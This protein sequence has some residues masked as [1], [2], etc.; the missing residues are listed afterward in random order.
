MTGTLRVTLLATLALLT[1]PV[2]GGAQAPSVDSLL[3][4]P[5]LLERTA[6]DLERRVRE[7]EI[8]IRS[9][10]SPGRTVSTSTKSRD[11]QNWR[12]LRRGMKME[13]VR[14]LLGEPERVD[15][16][17]G[18][19]TYWRWESGADVHFDNRERLEGWSEPR[20]YRCCRLPV[21][22]SMTVRP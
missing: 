22:T 17:G 21:R 16:L 6:T 7:L 3:R 2:A 8:L 14:A 18:L 5:E 9:Q 10:S 20:V 1:L 4:R 11:L 15:A 13:E 19:G 12:R